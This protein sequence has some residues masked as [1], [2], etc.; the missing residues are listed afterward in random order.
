MRSF[1]RYERKKT[2]IQLNN[3]KKDAKPRRYKIVCQKQAPHQAS[4]MEK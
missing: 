3:N 4:R 1:L 2:C